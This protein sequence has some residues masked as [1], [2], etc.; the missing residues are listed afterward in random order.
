MEWHDLSKVKGYLAPAQFEVVLE[1]E[2]HDGDFNWFDLLRR[3]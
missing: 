1:V 3:S 2:F